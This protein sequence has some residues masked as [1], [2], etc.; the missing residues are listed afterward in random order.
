MPV[1]E[2]NKCSPK[3]VIPTILILGIRKTFCSSLGRSFFVDVVI[4]D[5]SFSNQFVG[6]AYMINIRSEAILQ[7]L[8]MKKHTIVS[9]HHQ[10]QFHQK[11]KGATHPIQRLKMKEVWKIGYPDFSLV[12]QKGYLIDFPFVLSYNVSGNKWW[13][14]WSN[15]KVM[16]LLFTLVKVAAN[17]KKR[18]FCKDLSRNY[19]Y[20]ILTIFHSKCK[21]MIQ[22][23]LS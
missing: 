15:V 10:S 8:R 20:R 22:P 6:F 18:A 2:N 1:P 13:K 11:S 21:D 16:A 12:F 5:Q 3:L 23:N 19:L 17:Q 7:W 14:K 4:T 9:L